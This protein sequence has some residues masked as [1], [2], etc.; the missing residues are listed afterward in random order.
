MGQRR[1][2]AGSG[3]GAQA[4]SVPSYGRIPEYD[5]KADPC[6]RSDRE[7]GPGHPFCSPAHEAWERNRLRVEEW[8][9][10]EVSERM[11]MTFR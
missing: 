4:V 11:K 3:R 7:Y 1:S 9:R 6:Y 10:H 5:V 2:D 8:I